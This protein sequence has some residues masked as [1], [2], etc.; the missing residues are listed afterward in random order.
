MAETNQYEPPP[1][2]LIDDMQAVLDEA[3]PEF[4]YTQAG[5]G[6]GH[7][8]LVDG[9]FDGRVLSEALLTG[10]VNRGWTLSK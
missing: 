9:Y 1:A 8:D 5:G 7:V 3:L 10:L 2:Y 6:D 4:V